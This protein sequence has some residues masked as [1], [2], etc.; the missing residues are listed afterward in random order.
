MHNIPKV[1]EDGGP[2]TKFFIVRSSGGGSI[3]MKK[4]LLIELV[5]NAERNFLQLTL[6][7]LS[8]YYYKVMGI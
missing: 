2:I 7:L 5:K 8:V 3:V 6:Q 4:V 1:L